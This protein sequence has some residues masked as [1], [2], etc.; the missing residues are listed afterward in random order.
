MLVHEA[1]ERNAIIDR[2]LGCSLAAIAGAVNAA[3]FLAV[4]YYSANMTGNVS[5]LAGGLHE[6]RMGLVL[7]CCGLVVAF[8]AG[9]VLSALLVNA[10]RRR[11]LPSIY[12]RS[13]LLEGCLLGLLG[14]VDLL[15]SVQPRGPTLAYGLSF[16]MGLQNATV[17]RISGARV[18]TTHMTGMLTDVGL[19]LADWLDGFFHPVSPA[20]RAGTCERLGLHAAIVLSFTLGGIAGAFLYGWWS[21]LFLLLLAGLLA[22]LAL[23]GAL[24]RERMADHEAAPVSTVSR[25]ARHR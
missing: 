4:G 5:A 2:R 8:V 12:A 21:G 14:A 6:G 20:R 10:G 13:I 11:R 9:A 1:E 3:G 7:S 19:E 25:P 15:F 16:L 24:S 17:T 18:R 23:P 22:C